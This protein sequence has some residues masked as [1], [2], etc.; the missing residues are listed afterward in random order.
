M[1]KQYRQGDVFLQKVDKLPENAKV[2]KD[3]II[4]RG[5]ATGHAHKVENGKLYEAVLEDPEHIL[6]QE[7]RMFV[8]AKK[9]TRIVHEE[10]G[11][12]DIEIGI[13]III[14]QREFG[15]DENRWILD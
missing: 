10:H 5:E 7:R 15:K 3:N 2:K 8:L 11:P 12:I 6:R 9:G 13:Y 1:V 4:L 14:R